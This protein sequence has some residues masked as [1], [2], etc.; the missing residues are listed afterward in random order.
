MAR[1]STELGK[2]HM[3]LMLQEGREQL[4]LQAKERKML[5]AEQELWSLKRDVITQRKI[6]DKIR[7]SI[8]N[9]EKVM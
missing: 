4:K 3:R 2:K 9:L 1:K 5:F 8:T 7:Q 6:R